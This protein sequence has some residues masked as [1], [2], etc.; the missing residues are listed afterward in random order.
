MAD[1]FERKGDWNFTGNVGLLDRKNYLIAGF[2]LG[3]IFPCHGPYSTEDCPKFQMVSLCGPMFDYSGAG[4]GILEGS[5]G[6]GGLGSFK[7]QFRKDCLTEE[8]KYLLLT[9]HQNQHIYTYIFSGAYLLT[10]SFAR[11]RGHS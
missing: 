3:F 6:G 11:N 4:L 7:R 5:G 9:N 1:R 2:V 8:S 10:S